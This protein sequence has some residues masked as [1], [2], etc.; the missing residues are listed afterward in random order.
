[1]KTK[2]EKE[3][4]EK[5]EE[6]NV[7]G[8]VTMKE[9]KEE[10]EKTDGDGDI[11]M[12]EEKE[13]VGKKKQKTKEEDVLQLRDYQYEGV[14]WICFNWHNNLNC[15]LADEMGLGKTVF[16][17]L[18]LFIRFLLSYI[19][20]SSLSSIFLAFSYPVCRVVF[21]YSSSALLFF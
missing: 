5:K 9:G 10:K 8:D 11:E 15:V 14:S 12:K 1:M 18:F 3:E 19:I 21:F 16:F 7:D 6:D 2:K 13:K 17:L 20:F 4:A